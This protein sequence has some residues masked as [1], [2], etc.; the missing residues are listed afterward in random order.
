M[1]IVMPR[2][3]P[4]RA[5]EPG[6]THGPLDFLSGGGETGAR[7]R[8]LDWTSTPL[9][10]PAGWPQSLKTIV[11]VMLDSR[12]AMWMLWGPGFTFFCNDAYLPT[13][14][15]KRDWVLGCRADKV[16]EEIWPDIGPRIT[17]VLEE[18]Q[19]TW[20]EGLLLF[21][22]RSGFSE[23]TYHTFSY[24]PVYDDDSRIAGMLCVVTE[25]TDRVIGERRLRS[26][27]DL[28]ARGSGAESVRQACSRLVKVLAEDPF[29]VP[30][31]LL[32]VLDESGPRAWLAA[33]CGEVP[34]RLR[35]NGFSPLDEQAPWPLREVRDTGQAQLVV[36]A[37]SIPSPL[38]SDRISRAIVLPVQ[39][40]GSSSPVAVLI[41]GIS[42]RR[43]LEDSY[44]GFFE[45][46]CAQFAAAI[47]DAQAYEAER[48]RVEALAEIDR[49]KTAFF[50][51]VSHEFR[52][53]LAL[54]LGPVEQAMS[55]ADTTAPVR[56][57]LEVAHRNALRLLKLV[58]S[59]L[60]FSQIE[61]GRAQAFYEPT[62]LAALTRDLASAFRSTI[63]QAE[64]GFEVECEA[65]P[66]PLYVDQS[67]WEKVVLNLISNAFKF[68]LSGSISIRMAARDG[69]A[70]LE[71]V[72]SGVGVPAHEIPRLFERFHRVEGTSGR[73]HEGSGIGLALVQEILNLHGA[74]IEAESELG[75]GTTF[76]V[77]VPFGNAHLP[78]ER[79]KR[80]SVAR[81]AVTSQGFVHE[82]SRWLTQPDATIAADPAAGEPVRVLH[83]RFKSTFGARIVLADD[84]GDMRAYV[85]D[86]LAP[87]Y[88]VEA[89]SDGEQALAAAR[90]QRPDLI[91]S[92]VMMPR[93]DGMELLKALRADDELK[94]IPVIML[95]ARAG[96]SSRIE[97]L[98]SG[99]DDY[100]V[101]P[102]VAR[103]LLA[104]VGA[105]IELIRIRTES[106]RKLRL[107]FTQLQAAD[108]Q[109]DEFLAML[110]HE[111]RNPLSP[112]FTAAEVLA[113]TASEEPHAK[114]AI[115]TIKRQATQLTR[116]VD[117]LLDISR[118]T[119]GRIELKRETLELSSVITQAVETVEPLLREK[120]HEVSI[121]AGYES[122]YVSGDFARLVQCVVNVLTNAAKYT[123]PNGRIRIETRADSMHA[124]IALSD[125]GAGM[126]PELLPRIFDLFVQSER[127]LDRAQGGLG[128]G[129]SVVKKL[130]QMHGGEIQ[131]H[132]A[133]VGKGSTFEIKL[134]RVAPPSASSGGAEMQ[135]VSPRRVFIVDDNADAADSLAEL[136]RIEGHEAQA[137]HS[138][139]A[140]LELIDSFH[141]D[142]ALLDIGLP[143]MDGFEL[144]RRLRERPALAG[145]KFVALTGYGQI[146]DRR[147]VR[148]SGFD[149]HLIKPIDLDALDRIFRGI[150]PAP[151]TDSVS[152]GAAGGGPPQ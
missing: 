123:D 107:A 121:T 61:A 96:E 34:E 98:D 11:R 29:D 14:G 109:K 72:D 27:R 131:A 141:P 138:P 43:A 85:R 30:F 57:Q 148:E 134:P 81:S 15:L 106:E 144:V 93:L 79:I 112:I 91:L 89:V 122:L 120:H 114:A 24:S 117:D 32:Y 58:N 26:L 65:L 63:E 17:Q 71:V 54:M 80:P 82:A 137:V 133:G 25:V 13:V 90:R 78:S 66:G 140:A 88:S 59:L 113:R 7:L 67:M 111:L 142:I 127:T 33:T 40:Q 3:I 69:F 12:Y 101:K 105:S 83:Q 6:R 103:E 20:D 60:D 53:P 152:R 62:D 4:D 42:P 77:R 23:E 150:S 92:D 116:L 74:T 36:L 55:H 5:H 97:G 10:D 76:R 130:L 129:L 18:G 19:A 126:S 9:G 87:F 102:F 41:S 39:G 104:R 64:L 75:R 48:R 1:N 125:T 28:A 115:A 70:V 8:E 51:N 45:L 146:E 22:E 149:D 147:R 68:T 38:W 86:L 119:Q 100:L 132:S 95:S 128:I 108:R 135:K 44:R 145:V 124:F 143:D 136:L 94:D 35:P 37:D 118:I 31:A 99:A 84:N 2:K 50:S 46:I 139:A 49:A 21:L 52:T 16:W 73:T 56:R 110:A 151:A 47:A